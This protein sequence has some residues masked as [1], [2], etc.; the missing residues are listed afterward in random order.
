[1]ETNLENIKSKENVKSK[2]TEKKTT[3]A[4]NNKTKD[5][6]ERESKKSS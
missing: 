6:G 1:M 3:A 5:T 4:N 2:E